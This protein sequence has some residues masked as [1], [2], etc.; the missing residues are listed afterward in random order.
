MHDYLVN[1]D[2]VLYYSHFVLQQFEIM[3][4]KYL[5]AVPFF[6]IPNITMTVN[7]FALYPR[8]AGKNDDSLYCD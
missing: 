3:K 4:G 7:H 8:S 6:P 2:N 5:L 1:Y